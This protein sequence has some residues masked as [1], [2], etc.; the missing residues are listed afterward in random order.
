MAQA[1]GNRGQEEGLGP[2]GPPC[3]HL[4]SIS[5]AGGGGL[6]G[7]P[8]EETRINTSEQRGKGREGAAAPAP[9]QPMK[10]SDT[11]RNVFPS[12][13]P[14]MGVGG[15]ALRM[16]RPQQGPRGTCWNNTGGVGCEGG[17]LG[18]KTVGG[19]QEGQHC[20]SQRGAYPACVTS[21][22]PPLRRQ[23]LIGPVPCTFLMGAQH[24]GHLPRAPASSRK[25]VPSG[26]FL[27]FLQG[28]QGYEE[29]ESFMRQG[30]VIG[31]ALAVFFPPHLELHKQAPWWDSTSLPWTPIS[32]CPVPAGNWLS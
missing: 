13:R 8:R 27:F 6:Q 18:S 21:T 5:G 2:E 22:P 15:R 3:S 30:T 26:G 29:A 23:C 7:G 1:A 25:R 24:W 28:T 9:W 31:G 10:G 11:M 4:Q 14:R 32:S 20:A 17:G 19:G 16:A 12:A